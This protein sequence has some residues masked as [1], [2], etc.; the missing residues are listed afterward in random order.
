MNAG[1]KDLLIRGICYDEKSSY[2]RGAARAPALIRQALH[3]GS[4]NTFTEDLKDLGAL[5]SCDLGDFDPDGYFDIASLTRQHL[6]QGRK[7]FTLGGDHSIT[8][9]KT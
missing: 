2:L 6:E 5:D 3:S 1:K 4:M 7:L 8:Y 9:P